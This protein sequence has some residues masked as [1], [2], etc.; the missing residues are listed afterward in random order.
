MPVSPG[1][2]CSTPGNGQ[3]TAT[4]TFTGRRPSN[5]RAVVMS[6]QQ[7]MRPHG[8][9]QALEARRYKAVALRAKGW[10]TSRIARA[11]KATP[12]GVGGWLRA[13]RRLGRRALKAKPVPGRPPRLLAGHRQDLTRRLLKGAMANGFATDLWTCP[14]ITQ[15]IHDRYGVDYHCHH[16]PRLMGRLG[17]SPSE[18]PAACPGAG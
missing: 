17:F 12:Q 1:A 11:V 3:E 9:P 4:P 15:L 5:F 2:R 8:S 16:I 14:R 18:A 7:S 10:S 13:C 6:I